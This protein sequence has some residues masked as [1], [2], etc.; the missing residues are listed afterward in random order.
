M[1]NAN[2]VWQGAVALLEVGERPRGLEFVNGLEILGHIIV[3]VIA[4]EPPSI[5]TQIKLAEEDVEFQQAT[6]FQKVQEALTCA[7]A[8]GT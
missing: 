6:I 4:D 3:R 1:S 2:S 7:S 5:E 8:S